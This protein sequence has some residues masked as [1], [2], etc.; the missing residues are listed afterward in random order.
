MSFSE[1]MGVTPMWGASAAFD[2]IDVH[3][4]A[5]GV[6]TSSTEALSK[7]Q[8][9]KLK[10]RKKKNATDEPLNVLLA[11]PGDIRH[12]IKTL[13]QR[14]R[15]PKRPLHFYISETNV[16][17]FARHLVLFRILADWELPIRYRTNVFLEVYGNATIQRRTEQYIN[18]ISK[19]LE[20]L[21]CDGEGESGMDDLFDFSLLKYK[22]R[23]ELQKVFQTWNDKI[24]FDTVGLRDKRL[25]SLY[26]E[27]YDFRKKRYRLG[28][29]G[30]RQALIEHHSRKAV[31]RMETERYRLR[32][33]RPD[34]QQAKQDHVQLCGGKGA[35]PQPPSPRVLGRH[36][37]EPVHWIW[38][39]LGDA[40][41][42]R[43]W[44]F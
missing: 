44:T 36:R 29:P 42:A 8:K 37:D 40:K 38:H 21:L 34:V 14:R 16:E 23:D 20:K 7:G 27:R 31:P 9:K 25:R 17:C 4:K 18:T 3:N 35:W 41:Q 1:G 11:Q 19:E 39:R 22:T 28:L 6:V 13:S 26:K 15:H 43:C 32:V 12:V 33:W 30:D 2:C 5:H 24:P 10:E